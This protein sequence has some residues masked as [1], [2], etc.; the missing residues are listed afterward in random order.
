MASWGD[1]DTLA[2]AP[3]YV[4]PSIS[5]D[6][7][8]G[9]VVVLADDKIVSPDHGL[10]TGDRVTYSTAG[11]AITGLTNG[12]LV[13]VI[14]LDDDEFQLATSYANAIAGTPVVGLSVLGTGTADTFRVT[15]D[16][17]S[18]TGTVVFV[19]VVE[20]GVTS[21]VAKGLRNPGWNTYRTYTTGDGR[22][23][24]IVENLVAMKRVAGTATA[25][26][27]GGAGDDGITGDTAVEDATVADS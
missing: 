22:T 14:R 23:R 2:D 20:A 17:N 1:T 5:I 8:D 16:E 18:E 21:N 10:K 11:S 27:D 9:A 26:V 24:H 12:D 19:D 13:W 3:K 7:T 4:T 6:A 25:T 15:P